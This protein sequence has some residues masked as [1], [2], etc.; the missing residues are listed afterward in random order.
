[1]GFDVWFVQDVAR[2]LAATQQTMSAT[3]EATPALDQ[4]QAAAYTQGFSDAIRAVAVAF[5]VAV[6][7]STGDNGPRGGGVRV[8]DAEPARLRDGWG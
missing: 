2:I 7:A 4:A 3:M 1:M 6:P 8:I 5:G